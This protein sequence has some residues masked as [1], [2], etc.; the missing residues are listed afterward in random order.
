MTNATVYISIGNS[1]DKLT[2][3][4]WAEFTADVDREISASCRYVGSTV[5]GRWY[6]LPNEPWQNACWCIEF[7]DDLVRFLVDLR[8]SLAVICARHR[9]DAITWMAGSVEFI[10]P[11][12]G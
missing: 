1:D 3:A 2:Q 8:N 7:A 5:H 6:S 9:Q 10:G 4:E 12:R 11:D